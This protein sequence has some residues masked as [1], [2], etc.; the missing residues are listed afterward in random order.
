MKKKDN[1]E[2]ASQ[3]ALSPKSPKEIGED[4][5][6]NHPDSLYESL[7]IT[8]DG[9]IFP[10]SVKGLN[11]AMNYQKGKKAAG[12]EITVSTYTR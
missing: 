4:Y 3:E 11:A 12:I 8:S 6:N 9:E 2:G 5:F 10:G 7:C 1:E